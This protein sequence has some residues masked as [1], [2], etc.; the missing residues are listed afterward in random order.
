MPYR[1]KKNN[2]LYLVIRN[3]LNCNNNCGD[4]D[5]TVI[6]TRYEGKF[7][8]L[9]LFIIRLLLPDSVFIRNESEFN[10]KF[11]EIIEE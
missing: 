5:Q 10:E 6:Y 3:A 8:R 4:D 9:R 1:N 7:I 11:D 2:N